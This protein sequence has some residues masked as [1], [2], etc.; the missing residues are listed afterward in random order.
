MQFNPK[1]DVER[2]KMMVLYKEIHR[3]HYVSVCIMMNR[4]SRIF[5]AFYVCF[6]AATVPW[7]YFAKFE[8]I[9]SIL[10]AFIFYK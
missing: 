9:F 5:I 10:W 6:W 4:Q 1:H 2:W 3:P 7:S 8:I